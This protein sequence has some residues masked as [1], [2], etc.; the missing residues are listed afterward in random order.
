MNLINELINMH[1]LKL[2]AKFP[3]LKILS[4]FKIYN[5]EL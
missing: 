2:I 3:P 1:I 5:L 4:F